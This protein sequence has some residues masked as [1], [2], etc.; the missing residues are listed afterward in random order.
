MASHQPYWFAYYGVDID[1][2]FSVEISHGNANM[3]F[4]L[5]KT[6]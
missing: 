5:L 4:I 1:Y 6:A 3:K 2:T